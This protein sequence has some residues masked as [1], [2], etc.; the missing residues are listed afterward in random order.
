MLNYRSARLQHPQ[1]TPS[2]LRN[3]HFPVWARH[4][5][6]IDILPN[7]MGLGT[8]YFC[9]IWFEGLLE[10][11]LSHPQ[12]SICHLKGHCSVSVYAYNLWGLPCH[13]FW[14]SERITQYGVII[15]KGNF[16]FM[17]VIMYV[18]EWEWGGIQTLLRSAG[19]QGSWSGHLEKLFLI[20]RKAGLEWTSN[21]TLTCT[22]SL[23]CQRTECDN[24]FPKPLRT[25][26]PRRQPHTWPSLF[27]FFWNLTSSG[28]A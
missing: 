9:F 26:V 16:C 21:S 2:E 23:L 18:C 3:T 10:C 1:N 5:F 19:K 7:P 12:W 6:T 11:P 17:W 22:L 20:S 25:W 13:L 27:A 4:S 8:L 24:T 28:K 15:F 14:G